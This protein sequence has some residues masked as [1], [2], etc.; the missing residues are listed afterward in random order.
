MS[1]HDDE[2]PDMT[3]ALSEPTTFAGAGSFRAEAPGDDPT[4]Y[5]GFGD[6]V[7]TEYAIAAEL[8]AGLLS[9]LMWAPKESAAAVC[10][11]LAAPR[12][13]ATAYAPFVRPVHTVV[14]DAISS[15]ATT[16]QPSPILVNARLLETGQL[17]ASAGGVRNAMLALAAPTGSMALVDDPAYLAVKVVDAHYR[18]GYTALLARMAQH[19]DE[20]PVE[21]LAEQWAQLTRYQ[22]RAE[23]DWAARR[24]ALDSLTRH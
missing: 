13:N 5:G 1:E 23:T 7:D 3:A 22:Q 9:A 12:D 14:F 18:R 4:G 21:E 8:E 15:V 6:D 10:A 20:T 17:R 24:D 11:V 19:R 2:D 16:A